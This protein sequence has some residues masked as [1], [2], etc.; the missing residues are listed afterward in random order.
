MDEEAQV[1]HQKVRQCLQRRCLRDPRIGPEQRVV[2]GDA[3]PELRREAVVLHVVL[4]VVGVRLEL[5]LI[6]VLAAH[7]RGD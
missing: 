5:L 1:A 2:S 4:H 7:Q 6:N 3:R